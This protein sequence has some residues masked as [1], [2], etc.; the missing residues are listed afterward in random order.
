MLPGFDSRRIAPSVIRMHLGKHSADLLT[1]LLV[2]RNSLSSA[3]FTIEEGSIRH[4]AAQHFL[5]AQGLCAELE[6]VGIADF[7]A[8]ALVLDGVR[9]P[10]AI[11]PGQLCA[12]LAADK[13]HDVAGAA[14][15]KR[16]GGN[17]QTAHSEFVAASFSKRFV[18]R[19]L[20]QD[21]ALHC[22][23]IVAPELFHMD[24]RPLSSTKGE[25]LQPGKLEKIVFV[26]PH[27]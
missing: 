14:D 26:K 17:A 16:S 27:Q 6:S 11:L 10:E 5:Q 9:L 22:T 18:M 13:F 4:R 12:G 15:P 1:E 21:L 3:R 20:M 19:P 25:M 7:A 2:Q 24:Q 23:Q 8:A